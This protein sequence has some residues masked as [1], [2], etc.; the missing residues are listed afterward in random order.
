MGLTGAAKQKF[1]YPR[2]VYNAITIDC[3][4][5]VAAIEVS[6]IPV[7]GR[8]VSASGKQE[9]LYLRIEQ[10]VRLMWINLE[11]AK[12]T[13][14]RTYFRDW[15]G[16]GKQ[17]ALTLDRLLTCAGQYEYDHYNTFFDKAELVDVRLIPQ[18]SQLTKALY[19]LTLVFRQGA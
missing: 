11:I 16:Q 4:D 6:E 8:N 13:A 14:L 9:T 2:L 15:G 1:F 12:I 18:R 3:D 7:A 5:P 17:A 19:T 10:Q